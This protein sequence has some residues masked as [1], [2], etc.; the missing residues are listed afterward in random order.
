MSHVAT[1]YWLLAVAIYLGWSFLTNAW[2]ITWVVWP[3]AGI[4]YGVV[5]A[6]VNLVTKAE[7]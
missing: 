3:I 7:D 6:I 4:M 2:H 1:I 5:I